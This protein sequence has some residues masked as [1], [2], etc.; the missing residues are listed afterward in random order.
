MVRLVALTHHHTT[1]QRLVP[2]A[3]QGANNGSYQLAIPSNPNVVIP[4]YY[5][6]FG[7]NGAGV[8]TV[9]HTIKINVGTDLNTTTITGTGVVEFEYYEGT[10]FGLPDFDSLTPISTGNIDGFNPV[11]Y[12]HLTLPTIYSV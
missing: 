4:G 1:D 11:S 9:G 3:I 7:F 10:W 12:T 6:I 2:L 8:P 5:W